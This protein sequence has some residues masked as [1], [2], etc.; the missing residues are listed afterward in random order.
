MVSD[1]GSPSLKN[2]ISQEKLEKLEVGSSE[3]PSV[4]NTA[5]FN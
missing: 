4:N 2:D 3:E 1:L 5:R